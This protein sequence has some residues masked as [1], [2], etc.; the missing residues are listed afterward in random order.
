MINHSHITGKTKGYAH[1]CNKM[2]RENQNLILAFVHN[3][4]SFDFFFVLK[5]IRLCAWQTKQLNI[6]GNNLTNDQ[7][8]NIGCQVKF[9][10]TIKCYQQSLSSIAKNTN[11]AEKIDIRH[12]CRKF[13]E[14]NETY[15][16]VF[17]SILE[18]NKNWVL[19]YLFGGKGVIPY[20]MIK[21]FD[22]L[23]CILESEIFTKM[24]FYSSL[25]NEI[26]S[27]EN[28]ENVKN[29]WQIMCL[30]NLSDLNDIYNFQD[31]IIL[32]KIFENRAKEMM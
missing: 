5:G 25:R 32:C 1:F 13:I 16:S 27:D 14:K 18:G 8:A 24:E 29:L 22:D 4:F 10:G 30:K 6:G 9:I 21:T 20:E 26:I 2:L 28:Y 19:D 7:Y 11:E 31:T 15:S 23:D 17:N 12:S 3:L